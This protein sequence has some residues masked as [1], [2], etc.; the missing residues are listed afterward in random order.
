MRARNV[1]RSLLIAAA[2]LGAC[3]RP[4]QPI[5]RELT[6]PAALALAQSDT[7]PVPSASIPG[8]TLGP[9]ASSIIASLGA[10]ST[11]EPAL[12]STKRIALVGL[13]PASA[14]HTSK[15]GIVPALSRAEHVAARNA[16]VGAGYRILRGYANI[17]AV[18]VLVPPGKASA[19]QG[20]AEV[21]YVSPAR[22]AQL[23]Q[24]SPD[25][26]W[27]ARLI[28]APAAWSAG[29]HGNGA[30]ITILDSGID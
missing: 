11:L 15:T 21:N 1:E 6:D 29:S 19:L 5:R 7:L 27:G 3:D 9:A 14:E 25:T 28:G 4:V 12:D 10:L 26:S 18:A 20:I 13:K 8:T 22:V 24:S 2:W 23:A 30:N 16:I 17:G